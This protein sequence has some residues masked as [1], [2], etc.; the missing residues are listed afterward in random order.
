[1][2]GAE[3]AESTEL[4]R[5]AV[6]FGVDPV[7]A[8]RPDGY[9]LWLD[10]HGWS[11]HAPAT[12]RFAPLR[13]DFSAGATGLRL[14]QAGRRQP[15]ARAVGLKPGIALRV[16]DATAGLGRDGAVL[17][18][19]GCEVTMIERSPLMALLLEDGWLRTAPPAARARVRLHCADAREALVRLAAP[20]VVYLDPMYPH[21][22]KS[23]LVKKEM[24][25]IRELVGDDPD[26]GEL[27]R[28]ALSSGA[29]RVVVKR[30]RGALPL[31]GSPPL[32]QVEG[33]NTRYDLYGTP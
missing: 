14:R 1:M 5:V 26:A 29:R 9:G 17:A 19:L 22:G 15:L 13:L 3:D 31:D 27:L 30:P 24:R 11:L 4:R 6:R 33:P 8:P 2:G 32:R 10:A 25:V 20:D 12:Q 16:I 21:R 7:P 23:A 28:V 18:Q